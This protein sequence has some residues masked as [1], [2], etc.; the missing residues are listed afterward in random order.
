MPYTEPAMDASEPAKL[1][2]YQ[3]A[4]SPITCFLPSCRKP[5]V[6]TCVRAND[7]HFYCSHECADLAAKV[8]LRHVQPF[9]ARGK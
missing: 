1:S 8:D 2:K 9:R 4:G 7:G 5:F 6:D 3:Q